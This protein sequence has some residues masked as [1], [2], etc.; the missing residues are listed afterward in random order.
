MMAT[1]TSLVPRVDGGNASLVSEGR[2][3]GDCDG[4]TILVPLR[5]HI[6]IRMAEGADDE[7]ILREV[8]KWWNED[9]APTRAPRS[10]PTEVVVTI[11]PTRAETP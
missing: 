11:D 6:Q 7:D 5:K 9:G 8:W 1:E 4:A 3:T 2:S 10:L